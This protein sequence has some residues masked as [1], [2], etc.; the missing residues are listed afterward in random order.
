[1]SRALDSAHFRKIRSVEQDLARS[2]ALRRQS[3]SA[4]QG[5]RLLQELGLAAV[6]RRPARSPYS[7]GPLAATGGSGTSEQAIH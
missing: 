2:P 7:V 3:L 1:M 5:W 4:A 6:M